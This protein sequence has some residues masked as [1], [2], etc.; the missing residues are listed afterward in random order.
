ADR[1]LSTNTSLVYEFQLNSD[2]TVTS[3]PLIE[4][5]DVKDLTLNSTLDKPTVNIIFRLYNESDIQHLTFEYST[6][7]GETWTQAPINTIDQNTYSTSFTIYGAQ[8][9]V[10]LRIN[11]TD[12]NG[13][14]MS[15]TT[16]KGFFVKGALTLDYFP[17]PFLKDDGTINFAFV[18]GATW[19]HGRHNY[20]ASVADI[21]GSTLIA[22]RMRP[23][24]P[25]QSS[26]ISYHD[27]DVVGY[28]PSTGNMWIGDTAYPTLISVGGPGVNMLFDYYNNILP[29][30]FSKEGGWHIE[31]TTGN[32]Y[33][34]E[35]DEYGRTVEDYAI[36]AIHYDAETS[37]Y[38]MLIGGIG[39]EGSVAA[40]KYI[41]DFNS[42]EGRAM[43]IKVS[44]G[45]GDGI[46]TF[47]NL[48][49]GLEKIEVI[50]IIR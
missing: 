42:L 25:I 26:F 6:N 29:A 18:L 4:N 7:D 10:S 1:S 39:A 47:W 13:L 16:I 33:W 44:D 22:L 21:I 43:V 31:T 28:N 40:S 5:I 50:E 46:V 19:P 32:E 45:N 35:L 15:A 37:R 11:A 12:S 20:G 41:A 48:I 2:G 14:K 36:I 49:H 9:Y 17:Q 30:Y 34:R 3:G 23:N 27:T 8:Q 24:Q 38:F